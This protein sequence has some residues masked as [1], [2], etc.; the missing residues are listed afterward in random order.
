MMGYIKILEDNAG[1]IQVLPQVGIVL[2][3]AA[4]FFGISV[5]RLRLD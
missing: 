2:A 4:A 5:W 1:L 3:F